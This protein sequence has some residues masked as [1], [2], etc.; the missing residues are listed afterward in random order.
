MQVQE[1]LILDGSTIDLRR[2]VGGEYVA[3][4]PEPGDGGWVRLAC[5][6][7]A[8]RPAT[9]NLIEASW[10]DT[11]E[12]LQLKFGR[13]VAISSAETL[14][15]QPNAT[16]KRS[17]ERHSKADN[18]ACYCFQNI[19]SGVNTLSVASFVE[20]ARPLRDHTP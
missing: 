3:V 15:S 1:V 6:P 9:D 10:Q 12:Y 2:L 5:L 14:G 11:I 20:A 4:D 8:L 17:S 19:V 16:H 18:C 13:V 7:L